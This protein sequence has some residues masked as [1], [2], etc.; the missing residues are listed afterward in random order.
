MSKGPYLLELPRIGSLLFIFADSLGYQISSSLP[1]DTFATRLSA[2]PLRRRLRGGGVRAG[3]FDPEGTPVVLKGGKF[4]LKHPRPGWA[5][6]DPDERWSR[7]VE[8]VKDAMDEGGLSPEEIAGIS[9]D[10]ISSTVLATDENGMH[11][12]PAI[13]WMDVR[14][15]EQADRIVQTEPRASRGVQALRRPVPGGLPAD[16]GAD[17]RDATPRREHW[18]DRGHQGVDHGRIV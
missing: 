17:A 10:A 8:A 13:M 5:E 18:R 2:E 12:R 16:E 9:V 6:Q 4:T 3:I 1:I 11:L 15:S 7:T 14:A